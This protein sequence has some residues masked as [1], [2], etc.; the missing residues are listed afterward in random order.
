MVTIILFVI[1]IVTI[2]MAASV[3]SDTEVFNT[4]TIDAR[5]KLIYKSRYRWNT[6]RIATSPTKV[7][8][9]VIGL[10]MLGLVLVSIPNG[11]YASLATILPLKEG[12]VTMKEVIENTIKALKTKFD[13]KSEEETK[14]K[15]NKL[16]RGFIPNTYT[17]GKED[18]KVVTYKI[19][20]TTLTTTLQYALHVGTLAPVEMQVLFPASSMPNLIKSCTDIRDPQTGALT[21]TAYEAA[22]QHF[23][24][25]A[26]R[27]Y[28]NL[29]IVEKNLNC[30]VLPYTKSNRKTIKIGDKE[31]VRLFAIKNIEGDF[32][33]DFT[34]V[35]K[36]ITGSIIEPALLK[37][38]VKLIDYMFTKVADDCTWEET[39]M[40]IPKDWLRPMNYITAGEDDDMQETFFDGMG[41]RFACADDDDYLQ[42]HPLG[43][44]LKDKH[45]IQVRGTS[46]EVGSLYKGIVR[47]VTGEWIYWVI[48]P[49]Y[50]H[51]VIAALT[52]GKIVCTADTAKHCP[53]GTYKFKMYFHKS[54]NTLNYFNS[55]KCSGQF[56]EKRFL[57]NIGALKPI[58]TEK[59]MA[60]CEAM[61]SQH[62]LMGHISKDIS[63]YD[64]GESLPL[65]AIVDGFEQVRLG[66]DMN[67]H[68]SDKFNCTAPLP[69]ILKSLPTMMIGTS[70]MDSFNW[71]KH[72]G[73]AATSFGFI[74]IDLNPNEVS[75]PRFH[76]NKLKATGM[77]NMLDHFCGRNPQIAT[78]TQKVKLVPRDDNYDGIGVPPCLALDLGMD[79]DGDRPFIFSV[80]KGLLTFRHITGAG[81]ELMRRTLPVAKQNRLTAG[82]DKFIPMTTVPD[83]A[84]SHYKA[85]FNQ[86]IGGFIGIAGWTITSTMKWLQYKVEREFTDR[87]LIQDD[88][89]DRLIQPV[90]DAKKH[91]ATDTLNIPHLMTFIHE[92]GIPGLSFGDD[93]LRAKV[94]FNN[95]KVK[96]KDENGEDTLVK[97][98]LSG[99]PKFIKDGIT[100]PNGLSPVHAIVKRTLKKNLPSFCEIP[101]PTINDNAI[102]EMCQDMYNDDMDMVAGTFGFDMVRG[103]I[104]MNLLDRFADKMGDNLQTLTSEQY[105][106]FCSKG[107]EL[108]KSK[109]DAKAKE[110]SFEEW[111]RAQFYLVAY[112]TRKRYSKSNGAIHSWIFSYVYGG[113]LEAF[114]KAL[115]SHGV[116]ENAGYASDEEIAMMFGLTKDDYNISVNNSSEVSAVDS[117]SAEDIAEAFGEGFFE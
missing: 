85:T 75:I 74:D 66:R 44:H 53:A 24:D 20:V 106:E 104:R 102:D 68:I 88:L 83:G 14:D 46:S 55:V 51:E 41:A 37:D 69:S 43:F 90:I 109:L 117:M 77:L 6:S 81:V 39:V 9:C 107:I 115:H 33:K 45:T 7:I 36:N 100:E 96:A 89:E 52:E 108:C 97:L 49:E 114:F 111:V 13:K 98:Q 99:I 23:D 112:A 84:K 56:F 26:N 62:K 12:G 63:F 16:S 67:L 27:L 19:D 86:L 8:L 103:R 82:V 5:G 71:T 22:D 59:V 80:P 91:S 76:Y 105:Q 65:E 95:T 54:S 116:D 35:F 31:Y 11:V 40:V 29:E 73:M 42:S 34:R 28:R 60:F 10:V 50:V 21:M 64:D 101:I 30:H 110:L 25:E 61:K 94:N 48:K 15:I 1:A 72:L 93:M 87:L 70:R 2:I 57:T 4:N 3:L 38:V 78:S 58:I 32:N 92:T 47:P 17:I 18:G 79:S 113:I